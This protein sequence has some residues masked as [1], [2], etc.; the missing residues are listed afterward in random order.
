MATIRRFASV[1]LCLSLGSVC[2][3]AANAAAGEEEAQAPLTALDLKK[4]SIEDLMELEVTSVSK[5]PERLADAPSSVF[6][7]TP[8]A[9]RRSGV[10]SLAE[11]LRLAPNLQVARYDASQY[12]ISARGFNNAVGNK[13]LVL[14][15]GRTV[16][17]PLFSGVF[18]EQQDIMLEDVDRIEVISGPGATLWGANAVNGVIN[19]ITRRASD[20]QGALVSVR[21]G[22]REAGASLRFGAAVGDNGHFRIYAK[23]TQLD[24]TETAAGDPVRD[25]FERGQAGFRADWRTG[26]DEFTLQGDV[27]ATQAEDRGSPDFG[28]IGRIETSGANLLTRWTRQYDTSDLRIQAYVDHS[29]REDRNTFSPQADIVDF[30]LE[31]S[32]RR[33]QHRFVWGGGYRHGSDDVED[34]T[35]LGIIPSGF[36]PDSKNSDWWNVFGQADFVLTD[37]LTVT[38]GLKFEHND[39]TG[40]EHLPSVR[41]AWKASPNMSVWSAVSRAVRAPSR[42]DRELFLPTTP[43][44]LFAGGPD[45][46]SEVAYVYEAGLRGQVSSRV[47]YSATLFWHEWD[48]LR[49]GSAPVVTIQNQISGSAYGLE[50]WGTWEAA[51]G[52]RLSGGL[53][54]L[55]KDLELAPGST[56]PTGVNNPNLS[57]DPR[58][59]AMLRASLDVASNHEL[60]LT[61]RHVGSLP[62]PV[63]PSYTAVDLRYAWR[64]RP[65]LELALVVR[66]AFDEQHAEFDAAPAR[67]EVARDVYG[68][69][70]WSF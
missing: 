7:I 27:H 9:I 20:T 36:I 66:N 32:L 4:L 65:E 68:Q 2:V 51:E 40:I 50:A 16:Y 70:R 53:M 37:S 64:A 47:T 14:I 48:K 26:N 34:G 41:V 33:G 69:I 1:T 49:S 22:D 28:P 52:F 42:I 61:L 24:H 23:G 11:A 54:T 13:L 25:G 67:S 10:T 46:V 39:Y 5:Q 62:H 29:E 31:H 21:G 6:V 44:F 15:D 45:F 59:Q 12:A 63:V 58:Q 38:A 43:P 56:D 19:V 57:N 60:D 17:T 55:R 35:F 18:W 3:P 30:E 8:Y